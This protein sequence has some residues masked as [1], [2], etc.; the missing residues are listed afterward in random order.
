MPEHITFIM[1]HLWHAYLKYY[2]K[3]IYKMK[4]NTNEQNADNIESAPKKMN[5]ATDRMNDATTKPENTEEMEVDEELAAADD[6][7]E[8]DEM[9]EEELDLNDDDETETK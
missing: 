6:E 1:Q 3:Y 2:N 7:N 5:S 9:D 8:D 4:N